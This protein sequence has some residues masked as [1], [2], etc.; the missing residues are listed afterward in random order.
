MKLK[1]ALKNNGISAIVY[2]ESGIGKTHF[3]GTLKG[4]TLVV[5]A[6]PNGIQTLA[7]SNNVDNI[8]VVFLPPA[9][10]TI[11]ETTDSYNKFFASLDLANFDNL[12][13]DSITELASQILILH[14]DM[15]KNNGVPTQHNYLEVLCLMKYYLRSVHDH[16]MEGKN[17]IVI[18]LEAELA[19]SQSNEGMTTKC[20]PALAGRKLAPEAEAIFDIVAHL[21]KL[22]N[23]TRWLR[24][25]GNDTFV[26][27]D[28]FGRKACVFDADTFLSGK[29]GN[30]TKENKDNKENKETK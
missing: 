27:K 7:K 18:A 16:I 1:E 15:T 9:G 20:H 17:V 26:A 5:A 30:E 21:E 22:P 13:I 24:L 11:Q 29:T 12:V 2:G 25:E 10:K 19:L 23:G 3:V 6:E 8:E 4:R 28:R 14:T